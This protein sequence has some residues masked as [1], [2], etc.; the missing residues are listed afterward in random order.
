MP[1]CRPSR[2]FCEHEGANSMNI[3]WRRRPESNWGTGLCRPLPKPL[4]HAARSSILTSRT[5]G[6]DPTDVLVSRPTLPRCLRVPVCSSP[7]LLE[8]GRH[9]LWVREHPPV[10][11]PLGRT[12]PGAGP[13]GA[14]LGSALSFA[15]RSEAI[16]QGRQDEPGRGDIGEIRIPVQVNQD[17]G[18]M[19]GE[20]RVCDCA[21]EGVRHDERVR[22]RNAGRNEGGGSLGSAER[23]APPSTVHPHSP[24][25]RS[26]PGD[27][28]RN[29]D[30]RHLPRPSH[31]P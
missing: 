28:E 14:P 17:R 8:E 29:E 13:A 31:N 15:D 3:P 23:A 24:S 19:P 21:V 16:S 1:A 22:F 25:A 2:E 12:Q 10:A 18:P 20:D 27:A 9:R 5:D 26:L 7:E 6:L 30:P 11:R 4:G